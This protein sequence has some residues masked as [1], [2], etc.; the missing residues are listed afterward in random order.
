L[1]VAG[2]R[3]RCFEQKHP[4]RSF[5]YSF[6]SGGKKVVYATDSEL[7]LLLLDPD[8]PERDP[9]ALRQLPAPLV[10]F[11]RGADLL[12]ADG[13]YTD[14][15]YPKKRGW[16][17][18]RSNTVVDLALQAGIAQCAI[19]HHDPMHSDEM[20]DEMIAAAEARVARS[21]GGPQVFGAREGLAL[22]Y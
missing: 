6:E 4:G 21:G 12:I 16:G 19:F 14:A 9:E 13:Q 1:D 18:A 3:V 2:V 22:K 5:A 10:D 20:V 17:H 7:D 8:L 15:E 11:M